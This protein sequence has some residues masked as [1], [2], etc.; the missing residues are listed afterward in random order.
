[1]KAQIKTFIIGAAVMSAAFIWGCGNEAAE[2]TTEAVAADNQLPKDAQDLCPLT[3]EEFDTW[4]TSGKAKEN[5][6]VMP[7]NSVTFVSDNTNCNFYKWSEQMFLWITSQPLRSAFGEFNTI[8]ESPVFYTVEPEVDGSRQFIQHAPGVP[9]RTMSAI[10]QNGVN[11]LPIVHTKDGRAFELDTITEARHLKARVLVAAGKEVNIATV[12]RDEQG[13]QKFFDKGHNEIVN[14]RAEF[15]R[16]KHPEHVVRRLMVGGKPVFL[17]AAGPVDIEAGQAMGGD[18]L[19]SQN[20]AMVYYI[21][22]ANDVYAWFQYAYVNN[23]MKDTTFPTDSASRDI[24]CGVARQNGVLLH[25]SNALAME[26][27]TSWIET[28]FVED[29]NEFVNISAVIPKYTIT[30]SVWTPTGGDTTVRVS[31]V[32]MHIVGST[33]KHPEMIWATYEYK[34]NTPNETYNYLDKKGASRN[35]PRSD[36]K[37]WLFCNQPD[38]SAPASTFNIAHMK[39]SSDNIVSISPYLISSSNSLL[40]YPFGVSDLVPNPLVTSAAESN[41][42]VIS[43]NQAILKWLPGKDKRKNYI[44]IGAEWT[45]GQYPNG[46]S[47]PADKSANSAIGTSRLANSTMETTI[48]LGFG[49]DSTNSGCFNCHNGTLNPSTAFGLSHIFS[50]F[51][52][53]LPQVP[54]AMNK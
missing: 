54:R 29:S 3:K 26:I 45:D 9:I 24:I 13:A 37:G 5:G 43:S 14:P 1:M 20:G 41:S 11:N 22:F 40:L 47:Y 44:L 35:A 10:T 42:Q 6:F 25:D 19:M 49:N 34:K 33:N 32:G 30:D 36:T 52:N 27:K 16:F 38:Q 15:T 21:I 31:M 18:A 39:T 12:E 28:R 46:A 51:P 4:F 53:K 48:Q 17:S 50:L 7:A 2:T 23:M 8:L